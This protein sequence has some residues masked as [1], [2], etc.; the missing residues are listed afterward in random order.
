MEKVTLLLGLVVLA[1]LNFLENTGIS[2]QV[3]VCFT[4]II[5]TFLDRR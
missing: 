5:K 4:V 2:L 1:L 3:I